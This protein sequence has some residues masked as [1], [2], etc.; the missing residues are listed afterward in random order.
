[1]TASRCRA[2][3]TG[4]AALEVV[5]G[6]VFEDQ[7]D[8]LTGLR[9]ALAWY[10]DDMWRYVVACDWQR[11]DQELP[12]LGRVGARG[13]ELRAHSSVGRRAADRQR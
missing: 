4:Q 5:S 8:E 3:T 11:L 6:A 12:L 2:T 7:T 10:P 13:D 9:D 1:M